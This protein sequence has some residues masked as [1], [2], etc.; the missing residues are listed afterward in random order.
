MASV[1]A[2]PKYKVAAVVNK[3]PADVRVGSPMYILAAKS[4][5]AFTTIDSGCT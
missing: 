2:A 1:G 5:A 4:V 3:L